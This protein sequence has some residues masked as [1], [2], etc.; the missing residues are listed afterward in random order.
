MTVES[1]WGI[2]SDKLRNGASIH[3]DLVSPDGQLLL[4]AGEPITNR[5]LEQLRERGIQSPVLHH[6][7]RFRPEQKTAA[8]L[9]NFP[10]EMVRQIQASMESARTSVKSLLTSLT[11]KEEIR[12]DVIQMSAGQFVVQAKRDVAATLAVLALNGKVADS[13]VANSL[14]NHSANLSLLA[15]VMSTLQKD[16]PIQS[17]EIGLAGL[18][19]DCSLILNDEWYTGQ[20]NSRDETARKRYRRHS[21]ESADL[22]NG[23]SG[24]SK[25]VLAMIQEV[26]EQAD[27]SGYPR[28]LTISQVKPGTEILNLA[29]AYLSLTSPVQGRSI[30]PADAISYLCLHTAQGKFSRDALQLLTTSLSMYPV[31]SGVELDDLSEAVVVRGNSNAPMTPI[32]R[33]LHPGHQE[34][35]LR[36][37]DRFIS[38]P[39]QDADRK[40]QR[41]TKSR[42]HKVL[43]RTDS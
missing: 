3:F 13:E 41:L 39:L 19:H 26:H 24:I 20:A 30:V 29:D 9:S 40:E 38:R 34:I 25:S 43:W 16:E 35:D 22:L 33:L 15:T 4:K 18:L 17:F 8:L 14:A 31:G 6:A 23:L 10:P 11:N 21:I 2:P 7:P 1:Q 37:S 27:G 42:I 28:G 32:V 36:V 12:L 5:L